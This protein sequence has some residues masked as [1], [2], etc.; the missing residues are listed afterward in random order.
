[1]KIT[2]ESTSRM[3]L[4]DWN[5]T[6][7]IFSPLIILLGAY[8]ALYYKPGEIMYTLFGGIFALVGLWALLTVQII[9]VVLD[10]GTGRCTFSTKAI[11][12]GSHDECSIADVK[13]LRLD[14]KV[15]TH[16]SSKGRTHVDYDYQL[17]FILTAGKEQRFEFGRVPVH[18]GEDLKSLYE[19][20]R[21]EALPV[22][23]FLGIPLT[24]V[25]SGPAE[26]EIQDELF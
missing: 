15:K 26:K 6:Q 2:Q 20:K 19:R 16:R 3:T 24:G 11:F 12:G 14:K 7:I 9:S 21:K 18:Y 23:D 25:G 1:M 17:V 13:W 22:A 4:K 10:K 8:L 5:L